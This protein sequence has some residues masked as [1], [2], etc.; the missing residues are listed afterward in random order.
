MSGQSQTAGVIKLEKARE[1]LRKHEE[2]WVVL[3]PQDPHPGAEEFLRRRFTKDGVRTLHFHGGE[4]YRSTGTHYRA[5]EEGEI[6][7]ELWGFAA[8]A[9]RWES[10]GIESALIPF[11][12]TTTRVNNLLDATR[13][14]AF[15]SAE[16]R[17]PCW[18]EECGGAPA[19]ELIALRNGLLHVGNRHLYPH[20]PRF[21]T[22]NALDF[23]YKPDAVPEPMHWLRFLKQLWPDDPESIAVLQEIFAYLL[24]PDTRQ[25]KAFLI[26]GPKRSGKGTI[27]RIKRALLGEANVCAPTLAGLS[28]NFGLQPLIGKLLAIISDARLSGRA[29]Q[30]AIAE[31]LLAISGED[32]ITVDRKHLPSW[33]GKLPTRFLIL[34]NELPR[35]A[36]TSGALAARFVVLTLERSF[37]GEEDPHL[38]ER[39]LTELPGIFAWA[40]DGWDRLTER[41][42]FVQPAASAD[43]IRE[44]EDLGSPIS[45]FIRDRCRVEPG[46]SVEC[47]ALYEAWRSW[48]QSEGRD[49][50]GTA[51]TFGRDLRAAVP[52]LRV[53]QP[54]TDG[55]RFRLYE[56]ID[57]GPLF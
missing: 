44:M 11:Q 29:D 1:N 40:L 20:D 27:A 38:T 33:T 43:A 48:C 17:A 21:Y 6:R 5:A 39:L 52:G 46:R 22:H 18:L 12:P 13:A 7:A 9:K 36:D 16:Q 49:H 45:A 23:E 42:H 26:V 10:P 8:E 55:G 31:R 47:K 37:Y 56:G 14:L 2:Q 25:Q 15:L 35:I 24:L 51:Q 28:T 54:R 19:G 3:D 57:L 4:F 53:T 41:G 32:A 34:T 50:A 30:A